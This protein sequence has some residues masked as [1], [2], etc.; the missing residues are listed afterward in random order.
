MSNIKPQTTPVQCCTRLFLPSSTFPRPRLDASTLEPQLPQPVRAALHPTRV[1]AEK[2]AWGRKKGRC[3]SADDHL[4]P[5]ATFKP[6]THCQPYVHHHT[7]IVQ[8]TSS[9]EAFK[10]I[11][12]KMHKASS[13]VHS[14]EC[15][16]WKLH[17]LRLCSQLYLLLPYPLCNLRQA[18]RP[19]RTSVSSHVKM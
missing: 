6:H 12:I 4:S 13:G 15:G 18:L 5:L 1:G 10:L 16:P 19:L 11:N 14:K 2:W 3:S 17:H 9:F 7:L 8:E